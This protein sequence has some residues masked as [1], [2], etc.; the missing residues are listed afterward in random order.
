MIEDALLT[1]VVGALAGRAADGATTAGRAA[2]SR[3]RQLVTSALGKDPSTVL[4]AVPDR[5]DGVGIETL[6][7][8]VAAL[9]QA[10]D[11]DPQIAGL[12]TSQW[13]Q[14][15]ALTPD[16]PV[17]PG[18]A[19][20]PMPRQLPPP[21]DF[22]VNRDT[23]LADLDKLACGHGR[24]RVVVLTGPAGLG[25]TALAVHFAHRVTGR[26]PDGQLYLNLNAHTPTGPLS[27]TE[28]L[29]RCLR[30]IGVPTERVPANLDERAALWRSLTADRRLL[31]LLDQAAHDNQIL[32]VLPASPGC[33]V[34]VT[35]RDPMPALIRDGGRYMPLAPLDDPAAAQ[36]LTQSI[37][38]RLS[39]APAAAADLVRACAGNPLA[40]AVTAAHLNLHPQRPVADLA[41]HLTGFGNHHGPRTEDGDA[42]MTN[43]VESAYQ[44]L[45]DPVGR[46]Y[47]L[48]ADHP[49]PD[50][51]IEPAATALQLPTAEA[52]GLL[53]DLARAR[54]VSAVDGR[55]QYPAAVRANAQNQPDPER[56]HATGRI[57][58]WYTAMTAAANQILTPYQRHAQ[59]F[60]A[61]LPLPTTPPTSRAE[62]ISWLESERLNLVAAITA[63]VTP[64]PELAWQLGYL[65]WPLFHLRRHHADRQ[66]VDTAMIEA[67]RRLQ[68]RDLEAVAIC[69][70]AW[71]LYDTGHLD[72]ARINFLH[73]L[74]LAEE[75][76]DRHMQAAARTGFGAV[77][78]QT[79]NPTNAGEEFAAAVE[80]Y[81]RLD[82]P[83]NEAL[84]RLNLGRAVASGGLLQKAIDQLT[85]AVEVLRDIDPYNHARARTEL[86]RIQARAGNTEPARTN[87]DQALAQMT[88]L[89]APRGQALAHLR[90]GALAVQTG[91]RA[92]ALPHLSTAWEI[93]DRLGDTEASQASQL[94]ATIHT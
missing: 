14:L 50:I 31:L 5:S 28:T 53:D 18:E 15:Q 24:R 42:P 73:T 55:Y 9:R 16:R 68:R 93:L 4:P 40:L 89:E 45:P 80:L 87:L 30:S 23:Q 62:A 86:G 59:Q 51:T 7:T 81:Q 75:L 35:T 78:L 22:W 13:R 32:P 3:L 1:A 72:Q 25:K 65:S 60:T 56:S 71:G 58:G 48:L 36:L 19:V 90:L 6:L 77:L 66:R 33:L 69:R 54:L 91:D 76:G 49:G 94:L 82:D 26:F 34:L 12:L 70:R 67:A 27:P 39:D 17:P 21:T 57:I 11:R 38:D 64:W 84:A 20:V 41:A 83:R 92:N 43:A 2:L 52:A 88:A 74:R 29:G 63:A 79:D 37:G 61:D 85:R 8:V 10:A 44:S 46:A 47:R